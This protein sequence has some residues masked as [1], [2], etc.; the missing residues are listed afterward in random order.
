MFRREDLPEEIEDLREVAV[1][2]P[3]LGESEEECPVGKQEILDF[4]NAEAPGA[5]YAG[6]EDWPGFVL[7]FLGAFLVE[8]TKYWIW[9]FKDSEGVDS[10][11]SVA[12]SSDGK[13]RIGYDESYGLTPEQFI[14]SEH[15]DY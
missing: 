13:D 8:D 1:S 14:F 4:L 15:Y 11:V 3:P 7:Q 12:V 5:E 10:Y 2:F 9:G 6:Q